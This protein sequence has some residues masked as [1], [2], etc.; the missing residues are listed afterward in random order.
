MS[1][2]SSFRFS[3]G[4]KTHHAKQPPSR[5][6]RLSTNTQP[7]L[8]AVDIELNILELLR[9]LV[10]VGGRFGNGVVGAEDFERFAAAC[11]SVY[12]VCC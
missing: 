6:A 2:S 3:T 1:I 5:L 4:E 12:R 8:C 10:A 9:R 7:V 11:G